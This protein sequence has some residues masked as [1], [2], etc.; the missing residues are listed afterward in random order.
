[1]IEVDSHIASTPGS[2]R[3]GHRLCIFC[4]A[5]ADSREHIFPN[6]VN[7]VIVAD[8]AD[9]R[10]F[11]ILGGE[12]VQ[13][14]GYTAKNV[15]SQTARIVCT[16]CNHGWMSSLE[17]EIKPVI[18]PMIVNRKVR[19]DPGQQLLIA[20]W[21]IKTS[22]VAESVQY[23]ENSFAQEERELIRIGT[24]IPIRPRVSLAAYDMSEPNATRYTRGQGVVN[25]DGQFFADF[26]THTLQI[27]HLVLSVRGTATFDA[28]ENRSLDQVARP[29]LM[30]IPIWPPVEVCEWPPTHI[31]AES[32]FIE[33]SGGNNLQPSKPGIDPLRFN[34]TKLIAD[35]DSRRATE[36]P[37]PQRSYSQAGGPRLKRSPAD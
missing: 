34:P 3:G 19:L 21:A 33:Y 6:W 27:G 25:R 24:T 31:L 18:G 20:R 15:A 17:H 30:E 2:S 22:M 1:M 5:D 28:T 8:G 13:E 36:I 26:Y 9:A 4:G 37:S 10:Q 32:E 23:G 12:L 29:R 11:L 7:E 35:Y 14:R 16:A